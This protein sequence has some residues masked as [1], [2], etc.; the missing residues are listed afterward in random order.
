MAFINAGVGIGG[1]KN[2]QDIK[3]IQWILQSAQYY[4]GLKIS[5]R[6][7]GIAVF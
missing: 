7:Y 3:I 5:S 1:E 4:Y 2:N 6:G